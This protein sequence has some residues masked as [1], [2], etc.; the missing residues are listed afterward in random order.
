MT[1]DSRSLYAALLGL[2]GPWTIEDVEMKLES[3]EVHIRVA[4]P[5]G[6][7]WVCPECKAVAPIHDHQDRQWRH[8][9]TCQFKTVVHARV[10]RLNCP[11]HGIRQLQV[12]WAEPG[13]QFTALFEALAID[14]LKQ[15]SISAV[16][17]HLRISWDEAA[18]IQGRAVRRGRAR[19]RAIAPRYVGVDETSF[20]KGHQYVTVVS[21]LERGQV[22]D[23]IDERKQESLDGFWR[24]LSAGQKDGIEAVAMD[25]WGP[26]IQSTLA[27]LPAAESKIVFDKF[28]V[29]Q[30]LGDAVDRV[31]RSEH[32]RLLGEGFS[33]LTRTKYDW[34]RHP[35]TLSHAEKCALAELRGRVVRMG[36]AWALKE[37]AMA[38]FDLKA[39]WAADRNFGTWLFA[40]MRS[41]L[42]PIKR[43]AR[44][45]KRHWDQMRNYFTHRITNAGAEAMNARIQQ[46]KARS[47]GFRNRQRFRDAIFFHCGGLDLYPAG[48]KRGQ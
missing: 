35:G 39:Q 8:L 3:G 7:R 15:A 24:G 46:V 10:P 37:T 19:R 12:P 1:T 4:L 5:K 40:A 41:K 36:R 21:D 27:H 17:K 30:H 29:A 28:H 14:W 44:M 25:M 2:S 11:T 16:G 6:E 18:G 22:L 23:V 45:L 43:V 33:P 20:Q 31:R 32:R 47:R 42:E 34:L 38:I 48:I 13:S 26:Y 9:D